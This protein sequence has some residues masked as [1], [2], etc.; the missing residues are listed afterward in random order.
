M[1]R[2]H[3]VES[4]TFSEITYSEKLI[5]QNIARFQLLQITIGIIYFLLFIFL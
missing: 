4:I 2:H 1:L 5:N 3:C